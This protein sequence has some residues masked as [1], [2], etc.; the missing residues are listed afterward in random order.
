MNQSNSIL[1]RIDSLD[2]LVF[3]IWGYSIILY[4]FRTLTSKLIGIN[5]LNNPILGV[6]IVVVT[7]SAISRIIKHVKVIDVFFY[8]AIAVLFFLNYIIYPDNNYYLDEIKSAFLINS[9]LL[10]FVGLCIDINRSKIMLRD[11]AIASIVIIIFIMFMFG[12]SEQFS[13]DVDHSL[14][15]AYALLPHVLVLLWFWSEDGGALNVIFSIIGILLLLSFGTRGPIVCVISFF[16]L[17]TLFYKQFKHPIGGRIILVTIGSLLY[18]FLK[19]VMLFLSSL[20]STLGMSTRIVSKYL[21]NTLSDTNGRD[22]LIEEI[23]DK[24]DS[25]PFWG[26]G[27]AGD[28]QFLGGWSHNIY[29]EMMATFGKYPGT[30]LIVLLI[31][32]I[33]FALYKAKASI[34]GKFMLLLVCCCIE[35]L[36]SSSFLILPVF[37]L[38]LG[39]GVQIRRKDKKTLELFT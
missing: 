2:A 33:V 4:Y 14:G 31:A 6:I 12:G 26:Y 32:F 16:V 24:I 23:S 11:M 3:C 8:V 18:V 22:A 36:F 17:Y 5:S 15:Q 13:V 35:L 27:F 10:Y 29:Y 28:R 1:S 38:M 25:G 37:Y 7:I 20:F 30:I 34:Y 39:Y 19:P 21:D 9:A